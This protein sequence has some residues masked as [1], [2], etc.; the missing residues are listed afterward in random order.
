MGFNEEKG[1]EL[2]ALSSFCKCL[3][4]LIINVRVFNCVL[5]EGR[6]LNIV[7]CEPKLSY[8]PTIN[9][10]ANVS[11]SFGDNKEKEIR[12][13]VELAI[14]KVAE[15]VIHTDAEKPNDAQGQKAT[16][17]P[18]NDLL[19]DTTKMRSS[20]NFISHARMDRNVS[21]RNELHEPSALKDECALE[22]KSLAQRFS[23]TRVQIPRKT[24]SSFSF[25]S[26]SSFEG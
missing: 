13:V 8:Y 24:V 16:D 3:L 12:D 4:A 22:R 5:V 21:F 9:A 11:Y 6:G 14:E 15:V 20:S 1:F 23:D 10:S 17:R 7:C 19:T 25:G 18:V 26:Y 2:I